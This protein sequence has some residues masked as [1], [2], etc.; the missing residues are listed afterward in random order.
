MGNPLTRP[1]G[2]RQPAK[3]RGGRPTLE[4]ASALRENLLTTALDSFLVN[5]YGGASINQIAKQA[6]VSR[7]TIYR[8]F[9]GKQDLFLTATRHAFDT[10]AQHLDEVIRVE[11]PPEAVLE[12]VIR[13]IHLDTQDDRS[14]GVIRLT[15]IEAYRFPELRQAILREAFRFLET[16]TAYLEHHAAQGQLH[17]ADAART[18]LLIAVAAAGGG[19]FFVRDE[20]SAERSVEEGMADILDFVLYGLKGSGSG[21]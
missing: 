13:Y 1:D 2:A 16:L 7:D 11:D 14:N 5:G 18:A 12:K 19:S 4:S 17:V 21:Q 20:E 9:S 8:Q 6:G 10:M 3:R 15:M